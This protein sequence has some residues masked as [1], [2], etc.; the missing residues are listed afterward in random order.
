MNRKLLFY[1]A[2]GFVESLIAIAVV[3][4]A[5]IS[6]MGIATKTIASII[7]N[8]RIDILTREVQKGVIAVRIIASDYNYNL[9]KG[10]GI[11]T[12][13]PSDEGYCFFIDIYGGQRPV[14][15]TDDTGVLIFA[16][17]ESVARSDN[18]AS[19]SITDALG[20]GS[21]VDAYRY[22]CVDSIRHSAFSI[23]VRGTLY[24]GFKN[25]SE[26]EAD[27]PSCVYSQGFVVKLKND[28]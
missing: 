5:G 25:C 20:T 24:V 1:N 28:E 22:Y 23:N 10:N 9:V 21:S 18:N 11:T 27:K 13:F 19:I 14:F 6:L 12:P 15:K 8:E 3:S 4:I 2:S 26:K 17:A 16:T 7:R